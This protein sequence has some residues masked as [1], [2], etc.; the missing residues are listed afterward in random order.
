[1]R[2]VKM[3]ALLA[4]LSGSTMFAGCLGGWWNWA[5]QGIPGALLTEFLTDSDG[6]FDIFEDGGTAAAPDAVN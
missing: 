3:G 2:K 6:F 5:I 1:M 4:M